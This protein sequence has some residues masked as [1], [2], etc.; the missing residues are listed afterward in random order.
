MANISPPTHPQS[1][2][3]RLG[4][5]DFP[6]LVAWSPSKHRSSDSTSAKIYETSIW[7]VVKAQVAALRP[8]LAF[9]VRIRNHFQI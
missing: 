5:L 2:Q 6:R 8:R 1:T 4:I 3:N 7:R 9:K